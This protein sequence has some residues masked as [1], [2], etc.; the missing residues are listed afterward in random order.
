MTI[1]VL[2]R[3]RA[4]PPPTKA[5]I[6]WALVAPNGPIGSPEPS[7]DAVRLFIKHSLKGPWC[8]PQLGNR[9]WPA[10]RPATFKTLGALFCW[11]RP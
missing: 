2:S 5:M 6:L 9:T 3:L 1:S 11:R 4:C 7:S 8:V 10:S